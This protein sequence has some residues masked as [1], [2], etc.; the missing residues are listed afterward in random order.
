MKN[1]LR[2]KFLEITLLKNPKLY[3]IL[4]KEPEMS[5]LIILLAISS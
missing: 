5:N 1:K 2:Y 3:L 4:K